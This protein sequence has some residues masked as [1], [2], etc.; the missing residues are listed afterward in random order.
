MV[1]TK[2]GNRAQ[3]DPVEGRGRRIRRPQEGHMPDTSGSEGVFTKLQRIAE[4][5]RR[6]P[7]GVFTSLNHLLCPELL[8]AAFQ[9]LRK[10]GAPGIVNDGRF[11]RDSDGSPRIRP[12]G[13]GSSHNSWWNWFCA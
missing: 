7:D 4:A 1:P 6:Q 8:R 12:P 5:A 9:R 2:R 13:S 11:P 10:D 3:R